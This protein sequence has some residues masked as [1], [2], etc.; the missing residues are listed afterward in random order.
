[1]TPSIIAIDESHADIAG[2]TVYWSMSGEIDHERLCD[3]LRAV[4]VPEE[5]CPRLPTPACAL[6][7]ALWSITGERD[8]RRVLVRPLKK[9]ATWA[10]VHETE[11]A[12]KLRETHETTVSLD[13]EKHIL[14]DGD[15][16]GAL[17]LVAAYERA[18]I[19]VTTDDMS[20][21]LSGLMRRLLAVALRERGGIYFI[22]K[23]NLQKFNAI[24]E[25]IMSVSIFQFY[26]IPSLRCDDAVEAILAAIT[27]EAEKTISD[28]TTDIIGGT[29]GARALET[30]RVC[31]QNMRGKVAAYESLLGRAMVDIQK[32]LEGL[33]ANIAMA[34]LAGESGNAFLPFADVAT[35]AAV[36]A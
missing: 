6:H 36:G 7:R 13:A 19:T 2:A 4:G 5:E 33:D 26:K 22:P 14:M 24:T 32:G 16:T 10:L 28:V 18:R 27:A 9:E 25:A 3:A 30:R 23:Q 17:K 34:A 35:L 12:L 8:G 15:Q 31:C 21:W 29:L 20:G 11:D 1:M